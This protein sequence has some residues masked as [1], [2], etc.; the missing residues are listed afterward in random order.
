MGSLLAI[1]LFLQVLSGLFLSF[2]YSN[3]RVISFNSVQ[4]IMHEVS[5]GDFYVYYIL[6]EQ[7]FS[8]ILHI[9]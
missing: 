3:E 2:Y 4:F 7:D 1:V 6:M 9:F 5:L 8:F